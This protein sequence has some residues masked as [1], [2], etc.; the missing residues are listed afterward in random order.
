MIA[1]CGNAGPAESD[2][3]IQCRPS[4]RLRSAL[5][6]AHGNQT[7]P[8]PFRQGF[9]IV[10]RPHDTKVHSVEIKFFPICFILMGII[11]QFVL[12]KS[13]IKFRFFKRRNPMRVDMQN[14]RT[15]HILTVEAGSV[16][17]RPLKNCNRR[18]EMR[19]CIFITYLLYMLIGLY[20]AL[21]SMSIGKFIFFLRKQIFNEHRMRYLTMHALPN[22]RAQDSRVYGRR[23]GA[24]PRTVPLSVA[25]LQIFAFTAFVHNA[26]IA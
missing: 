11:F 3:R 6:S 4:Q 20:R 17:A 5:T 9:Q 24:Q 25:N 19:F 23:F 26:S 1:H 16:N 13:G 10:E 15:F 12:V 8:I 2:C 22:D 7:F 14:N 21:P 18:K